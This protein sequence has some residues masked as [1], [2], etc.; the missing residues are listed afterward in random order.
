MALEKATLYPDG[1]TAAEGVTFDFNPKSIKVTHSVSAHQ[2]GAKVTS[3]TETGSDPAKAGSENLT[4]EQEYEKSSMT[5]LKL[6][7]VIFDGY[8]VLKNCELLLKWSYLYTVD[9]KWQLLNLNFVWCNFKLGANTKIGSQIP[10]LLMRADV[11]YE[12]FLSD[13]TP[14]RATVGLDLQ[15]N[16]ADPMGQNPTSGGLL[17]RSG[18]T[19]IDG[20]S[21]PG[22]AV[23]EYGRPG[24]WRRLAEANDLDDPLRIRPGST[25]YLPSR[26]EIAGRSPA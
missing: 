23:T 6:A 17:G 18:H 22:I 15:I 26:T 4:R 5:M 19:V 13:G 21:L 20:D 8:Q 7:D 12:R 24:D 14:V 25:L 3:T 16:A 11:N 10:V 2:V 1:A 9:G